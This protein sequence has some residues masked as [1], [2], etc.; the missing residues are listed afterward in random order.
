MDGNKLAIT[1]N[2]FFKSLSASYLNYVQSKEFSNG[3]YVEVLA[4]HFMQFV[5]DSHTFCSQK[6]PYKSC[7]AVHKWNKYIYIKHL[8]EKIL[9]VHLINLVPMFHTSYITGRI[10]LNQIQ[11]NSSYCIELFSALQ[12]G[13][14]IFHNSCSISLNVKYLLH[15]TLTC[16][17]LK[18]PKC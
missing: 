15:L 12:T 13:F 1:Q 3:I 7:I 17:S 9:G 14:T 16:N 11:N 5:P 6:L 18:H 2:C 8:V 4:G 10:I